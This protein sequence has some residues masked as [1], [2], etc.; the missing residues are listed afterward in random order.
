M[1]TNIGVSEMYLSNQNGDILVTHALGSC[2]GLAIHDPLA[3]VGGILHY[4]LPL[5]KIDSDKAEINPYMFGDTGIP[6]FFLEAYKLGAK[7]ENISVI[8]AGGA[9]IF[10]NC[11]FFNIG[12]RNIAIARKM[13]WKNG[14]MIT[15]E[16]TGGKIPRT[17]YLEIGSGKSWV[18]TAGVRTDLQGEV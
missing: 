15:A 7:K 1:K 9:E 13:F 4:M 2:I 10:S 8:M 3:C 14:V 12:S 5:S 17:M 18:T 6:A 11:E 16:Q